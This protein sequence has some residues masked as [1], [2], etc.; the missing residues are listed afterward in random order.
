MITLH[1][2][3]ELTAGFLPPATASRESAARLRKSL[4]IS[5][6]VKTRFFV[7]YL[8]DDILQ[9]VQH[10]YACPQDSA[11]PPAHIWETMSA[12]APRQLATTD[13][14]GQDQAS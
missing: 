14:K 8:Q 13:T 2:P 3:A 7:L 12:A 11:W 5:H 10:R 1:R 6:A 4:V 9:P